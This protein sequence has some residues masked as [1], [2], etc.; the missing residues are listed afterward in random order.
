MWICNKCG[1][2]Q[3]RLLIHWGT[4]GGHK[5]DV[6]DYFCYH[7]PSDELTFRGTKEEEDKYWDK[8]WEK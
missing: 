4:C 1:K 6:L 5:V 7:C 8:E 2:E 3:E